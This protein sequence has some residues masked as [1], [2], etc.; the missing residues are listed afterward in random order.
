MVVDLAH[1]LV[2]LKDELQVLKKV[3]CS[4]AWMVIMWVN[5]LVGSLARLMVDQWVDLM[6]I[7]TV[8]YL[9]D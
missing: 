9:V 4:A 8:V 2:G 6:A 5:C 1:K 7:L 3:A